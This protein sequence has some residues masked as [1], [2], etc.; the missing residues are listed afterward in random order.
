MIHLGTVSGANGYFSNIPQNFKNLQIRCYAK[1]SSGASSKL[2]IRFN[3]DI[4]SSYWMQST[5][6][7]NSSTTVDSS[8]SALIGY[9]PLFWLPTNSQSTNL[10]GTGIVDVLNYSN[11]SVFKSVGSYGGFDANATNTGRLGSHQGIWNNSAA[12]T[13]IEIGVENGGSLPSNR[14]DLY[15]F[16]SAT[17][18]GA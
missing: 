8:N 11:T 3:D 15:G 12:V 7:I 9:F 16:G 17:E 6:S 2:Y 13:R 18:T 14:F 4:T 1:D 10:Y 5:T